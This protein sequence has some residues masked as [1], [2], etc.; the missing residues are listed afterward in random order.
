MA[1]P[2]DYGWVHDVLFDAACVTAVAGATR[3]EVLAA[4]GADPTVQL[5]AGEAYGG[6]DK[7]YVSVTEVS[8]GVVAV[9]LNGF[10]G[11]LPE[12][13]IR[14]AGDKG[15]ASMFWNVNDLTAF[16]CARQGELLASVD[17]Y[18]AE[19]P[20]DVEL[21]D[22]VRSL[23]EAAGDEDADLHAT[24]MAMVEAFTGIKVTAD[25]VESMEIAHP[26]G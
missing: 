23:F 3:A 18:D 25:L 4:F 24:G 19:D 2:E 26:I 6:G 8:G 17:M 22:E 14:V 15:A 21:P 1:S 10:Q 5:A 13:L 7:D 12:V 11:S 9:E 20:G 16:T